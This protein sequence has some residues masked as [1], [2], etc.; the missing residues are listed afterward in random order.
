[1]SNAPANTF[2]GYE[3]YLYYDPAYLSHN[4]VGQ[5]DYTSGPV[6]F[7]NPFAYDKSTTGNGIVH[8]FGGCLSCNNTS[9][10]T[11]QGRLVSITFNIVGT[12]V[13]PLTLGAGIVP[14]GNS[15]GFTVLGRQSGASEAWLV[16]DTADGYFMN[17]SG[18]L[19]PVAS[20]TISPKVAIQGKGPVTFNATAS[21]DPD[22]AA[23]PSHGI[24]RYLWDFGN[25]FSD[26]TDGPVYTKIPS[27]VFGFFSVRLTVVDKDD[28]FQ[29]MQTKAFSFTANPFHDLRAESIAATPSS[30]KPGAKIAV[31]VIV[32]DNGTFPENF[33]LTVAYGTSNKIFATSGNQSIISASTK[34]FNFPLDTTGFAPGVYVLTAKVI[35]LP[36]INNTQAIDQIP[37]NNIGTTQIRIEGAS[38]PTSPLLFIVGGAFAGTVVLASLGLLLRKRRRAGSE[39]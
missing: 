4:S 10:T 6:V 26:T 35:V 31:N 38:S 17:Q 34:S 33:N 23:A 3:F 32:F 7:P 8:V 14:G 20:F 19:G 36:S 28:T 11:T 12:G 9:A 2:H 1:V 13:S 24:S 27:N 22:N 29:G 5:I 39:D 15:R 16:P 30:A 18:K 37:A 21:F 25:G